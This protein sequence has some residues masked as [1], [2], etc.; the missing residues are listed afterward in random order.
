MQTEIRTTAIAL[1]IATMA[2]FAPAGTIAD[3]ETGPTVYVGAGVHQLL[4]CDLDGDG[5]VDLVALRRPPGDDQIMILRSGEPGE[6]VVD[7]TIEVGNGLGSGEI[8]DMNGDGHPD[9]VV[10]TFVPSSGSTV[11]VYLNDGQGLFATEIAFE[12]GF[13]AKAVAAGDI[14]G[15]GHTDLVVAQ[16]TPAAVTVYR[17]NGDTTFTEQQTLTLENPGVAIAMGRL[18]FEPGLDLV[19]GTDDGLELAFNDG[20]GGF[21]N[22]RREHAGYIGELRLADLD[23]DGDDDLATRLGVYRNRTVF[24]APFPISPVGYQTELGDVDGDG[25]IDVAINAY[26]NQFRRSVGF[27][28]NTLDEDNSFATDGLESYTGSFEIMLI[29]L[30]G[31][32]RV[33]MLQADSD[34]GEIRVYWNYTRHPD[35]CAASD[36]AAPYGVLEMQDIDVFLQ[37]FLDQGVTSDLAEPRGTLDLADIAVFVRSFVTGCP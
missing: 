30:N 20:A 35:A 17:N 14:D 33:E 6:F 2:S 23:G 16:T 10:V 29:D 7:S 31:D 15:D 21:V 3:F 32:G 1:S 12:T 37:S 13:N 5:S 22:Q 4:P 18:D 19:V 36:V 25:D 9:I 24:F 11:R 27:R 34:S 26:I 8:A 28:L